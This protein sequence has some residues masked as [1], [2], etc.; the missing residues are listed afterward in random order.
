MVAHQENG[1]MRHNEDPELADQ[2]RADARRVRPTTAALART[3]HE[4]KRADVELRLI[5]RNV[6]LGDLL[7]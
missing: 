1:T 6:R 2:P 4:T 5:S 7:P 3:E